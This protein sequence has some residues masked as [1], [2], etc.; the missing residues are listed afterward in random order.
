MNDQIKNNSVHLLKQLASLSESELS[1][2]VLLHN[3]KYFKENQPQITDEAFDKLVEALRFIN[4]LAPALLEIGYQDEAPAGQIGDQV[5]HQ[6]PML[7]L[8][9]CY[10]DTTFFKWANK[11]NGG[12]VA[13]PKID[14][15]ACSIKYSPAGNLIEASTRGDGKVGEN[16]TK[17]ALLI[18]D[19]PK[20]LPES[21]VAS[22]AIKQSFNIRGEIFLP[23]TTFK[24]YFAEE[25]ASPRNLAA[26]FLKLK[27]ADGVKS[28]YLK[29]FPYDIRGIGARSEQEKFEFL[30][31][32]GFSMMPWSMVNN[33]Q[34]ATATY[35]RFLRSREEFDFELDGVVFRANLVT[36]QM[37]LGETAH[38]PR[39]A[40]A[41]KF[42]G[43][44][45]P[46]KLLGVEWSVARSGIITPVALVEPVFVSG[47]SIRRASLHNLGIFLG[48]DLREESLVE[49]NRR[50][51]VIPYLERV[52]SRKG[53]RLL[54]PAT[55]PSCGGP[56]IVD[57]DFLRCQNPS[58]CETVVVSKLVHFCH[59]LGIDGLGEKIIKKLFDAGF[60]RTLGDVFRLNP[61]ML[62]SLERMGEVLAQKLVDE[63]NS[64]RSITLA[65]FIKALGI[66]EV[67]SN[68]SEL[69][70]NNW[71]SLDKIRNLSLDELLAVHGIG[72]S[73]AT[74]FIEGMQEHALEINDLLTEITIAEASSTASNADESH[75]LFGKTV[76]F[77]GKMAHLERKSAQE[78]VKKLGGKTPDAMSKHV[79]FLVIG[80]EKSAL[81]G[82]G[83]KSTKHKQA[84]KLIKE[85]N[86]IKI[87][88]EGEFLKMTTITYFRPRD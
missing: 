71:P 43:E 87:I 75:P 67:G 27:N 62:L 42:H 72:E 64:K 85:G 26:G 74:S 38:H 83:A 52:L 32:L 17:N 66:H 54:P 4:P 23:L 53:D 24:K 1:A 50:G 65:T 3:Q 82:D 21:V 37:R 55:C 8:E 68:V 61:Q 39:Y 10:D 41:Y 80:D 59:V 78:A 79:D 35:L 20:K 51:G 49:I 45:A 73:I 19:L 69:L 58:G 56:V 6:E 40:L 36:D 15:V 63:I 7:S 60:L 16:I 57:G 70:A 46:T 84:E 34:E 12:F 9:K 28:N 44:S 22:M 18:D 81:L 88:S 5:I 86:A 30:K 14:G 29:F 13:M 48:H 33:D 76:V 31:H 47:A 77:T 11:I 25:F 2:L